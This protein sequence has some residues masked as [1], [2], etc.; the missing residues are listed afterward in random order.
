[1]RSLELALQSRKDRET[2]PL[3][4]AALRQRKAQRAGHIAVHGSDEEKL[5][6][7][8]AMAADF[9]LERARGT[10]TMAAHALVAQ[11]H[12]VSAKTVSRAVK[13]VGQSLHCP[14][15]NG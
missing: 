12:G 14:I 1:M 4:E 7:W 15:K 13:I 9:E 10:K 3:I 8:S 2:T 6:R 5:A 11:K